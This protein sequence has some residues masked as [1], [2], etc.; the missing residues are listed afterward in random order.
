MM[1]S[2]KNP[3]KKHDVLSGEIVKS[4]WQ[5]VFYLP[6]FVFLWVWATARFPVSGG[7]TDA[8]LAMC[9]NRRAGACSRRNVPQYRC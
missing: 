4:N 8:L 5:V 6:V 2:I 1:M 9:A 7:Q 3:D